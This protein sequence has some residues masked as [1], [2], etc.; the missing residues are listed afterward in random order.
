[1]TCRLPQAV[2]LE[3]STQDL[4]VGH[5]AV[6]SIASTVQHGQLLDLDLTGEALCPPSSVH[7]R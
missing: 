1:M 7:V 6:E 5:V 3:G 2:A 4:L